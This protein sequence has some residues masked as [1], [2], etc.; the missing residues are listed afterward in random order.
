[1]YKRFLPYLCDAVNG[2]SYSIL[3][4]TN[5]YK[6]VQANNNHDPL[7]HHNLL[8]NIISLKYTS[9][10]TQDSL[11][12]SYEEIKKLGKQPS[13]DVYIIDVREPTELQETV[14]EVETALKELSAK[15]FLDKYG[16]EKPDK[17]CTII[18]SCKTGRRSG[19]AQEISQQLGYKKVKNFVGG[20]TEWEERNKS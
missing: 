20:W 17:Q 2:R 11:T 1:M 18:Y 19:K 12:A 16:R 9:C 10:I 3:Q 14:G 5:S 13:K 4:I 7:Q 15:Q 6:I 8:F